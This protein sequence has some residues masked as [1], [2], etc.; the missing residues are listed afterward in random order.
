M[1]RSFERAYPGGL[2][3]NGRSQSAT[4]LWEKEAQISELSRRLEGARS[5]LVLSREYAEDRWRKAMMENDT[6]RKE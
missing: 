6:L 2:M 4:I 3:E 5:D 1:R